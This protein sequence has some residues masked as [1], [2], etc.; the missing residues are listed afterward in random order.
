MPIKCKPFPLM[1]A[2]R[3]ESINEVDTLLEIG[4]VRW[5]TS[6]YVSPIIKAKKKDGSNWMFVDFWKLNKITEVDP[7]CMTTAEV[8]FRRPSG[9]KYLLKIDLSK[10][11]WQI[12]WHQKTWTRK[13]K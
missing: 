8:L 3:E 1:Y 12:V 2:L 7:E 5:S 11:Y 10:G 6:L 13:L 9:K 4:V